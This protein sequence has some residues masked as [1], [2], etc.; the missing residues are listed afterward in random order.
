MQMRFNRLDARS[1]RQLVTV[2]AVLLCVLAGLL[3]WQVH[4]G[5]RAVAAALDESARNLAAMDELLE[6]YASLQ[7]RGGGGMQA[8]GEDVAA[9]VNRTLQG[10]SF[11]PTRIQQGT[12]G[13]LQVRLDDV[14]FADAL[15]WLADLENTRGLVVGAVTVNQ[16]P[17]GSANLTLVLRGG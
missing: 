17:A 8:G 3:S 16:G 2:A 12:D 5:K 15:A 1:Q 14:A 7:Q 4:Q 13:E 10:R 9:V 11:Q 6:R